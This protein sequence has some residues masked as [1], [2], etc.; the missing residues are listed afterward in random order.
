MDV[1]INIYRNTCKIHVIKIWAKS[2]MKKNEF[3]FYTSSLVSIL[4]LPMF[5]LTFF[6]A[7]INSVASCAWSEFV[8]WWIILE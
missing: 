3:I 1:T 8:F 5:Y 7:V 2:E 6:S 4:P